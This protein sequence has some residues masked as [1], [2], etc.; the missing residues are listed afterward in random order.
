MTDDS[1]R[2]AKAEPDGTYVESVGPRQYIVCV[3]R[4]D[5]EQLAARFSEPA[6]RALVNAMDRA[7]ADLNRP[8]RDTEADR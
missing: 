3:A 8:G 4:A 1:S 6:L 5:G 7:G 2:L